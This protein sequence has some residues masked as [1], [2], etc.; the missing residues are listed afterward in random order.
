MKLIEINEAL[1][2]QI[3]QL[4]NKV[5]NQSIV[6]RL[7]KHDTYEGFKGLALLNET[8]QLVG[9]AYGYTSL[10]GQYYHGLLSKALNSAEYEQWLSHCFEVVEL[11]FDPGFR[12][13]GH[14]KTLMTELLDGIKRKTVILTTQT[15]N[16]SARSLYESMGWVIVKEPFYPG[17]PEKPYVIMGRKL[18]TD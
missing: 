5:W 10:P 4:Y 17:E 3:E 2:G 13:Q 9:F 15:D 7:K 14:A 11:A 18:N 12:R 1:L 8:D 16:K 6:E